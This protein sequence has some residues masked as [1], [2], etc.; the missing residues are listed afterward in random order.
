ML[1][2]DN[3]FVA[4]IIRLALFDYR[5]EINFYDFDDG[6]LIMNTIRWNHYAWN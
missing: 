5:L 4:K 1:S 3:G 2:Q 6:V